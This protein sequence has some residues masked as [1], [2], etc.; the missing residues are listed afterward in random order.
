[1]SWLVCFERI[2]SQ[3]PPICFVDS[4]I[5]LAL[6]ISVVQFACLVVDAQRR[7]DPF[8]V[9]HWVNESIAFALR[10]TSRGRTLDKVRSRLLTADCAQVCIVVR[11]WICSVFEESSQD[12]ERFRNRNKRTFHQSISWISFTYTS[13]LR[14]PRVYD[15]LATSGL[16]VFQCKTSV[17][18]GTVI[19]MMS[20]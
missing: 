7:I 19:C 8:S 2:S 1:M 15:I 10:M 13:L 3:V 18:A 17:K 9:F 4:R 16:M 6:D 14:H 11:N 12:T 5:K 20:L